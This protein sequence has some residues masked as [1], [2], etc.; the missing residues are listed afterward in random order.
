MH[1]FE[2]NGGPTSLD[3]ARAQFF[4]K[5]KSKKAGSKG[6]T[7]IKMAAG[8]KDNAAGGKVDQ[9]KTKFEKAKKS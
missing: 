9:E 3:A 4:K 7:E 8:K 1:G 5:V 2:G 6:Y